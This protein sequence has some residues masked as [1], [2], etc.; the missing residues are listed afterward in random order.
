VNVSDNYYDVLGVEPEASRE[1]LREAYR[2]RVDELTAARD[3][4][5]VTDSQLQANRDEV[6]KVRSAWNVLSDPF[7]RQRY[8]AQIIAP[9]DSVP[10]DEVEIVDESERSEVQLTGWR[11]FMAPPPKPTPSAGGA[12][13][14]NGGGADQAPSRRREPTI[15]LPPGM[16]LAEPKLRGMALLFDLAIV[17]VILYAVQFI[18]PNAIQ[19]DYRDKVDQIASLKEAKTAQED[20]DDA[21]EAINDA[22]QAIAKAET[23][24]NGQDLR[25]AQA[26]RRDAVDDRRDAQKDFRDAQKDFNDKQADQ[27]LQRVQLPHDTDQ[28]QK[29]A[30]DLES[31]IQGTTLVTAGV[32]LVLALLYLVPMT[33]KTG[34]TLGM[35][36]R[37]IKVVR[38]DGSPVGWWPAFARF[39]IPLIFGVATATIGLIGPLIAIG[40]VAWAFRDP[41][42]QGLHDKLARTLVV[43]A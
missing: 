19:S 32:T 15:A 37:K 14:R 12:S 16:R 11:R 34:Q 40:V 2:A 18:V 17:L 6:A 31:D 21:D 36:G 27:N 43:E 33:A 10:E 35:R 3:R 30:D 22:E 39:F 4:K 42:G 26:D 7:Q 5:G 28:L 20:I 23:S 13:G 29:Q 1:Q 8:D 24:G 41:N 9:R 38:V 25:D